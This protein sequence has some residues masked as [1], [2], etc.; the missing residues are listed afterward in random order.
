MKTP[1]D[2]LFPAKC[3]ICG[4]LLWDKSSEMCDDCLSIWTSARLARCP[5][6]SKTAKMCQCRPRFL[7]DTDKIGESFITSLSFYGSQISTD[8]RDVL[9]RRLVYSVKRK[10]SKAT[11]KFVARELSREILRILIEA[12][13]NKDDFYLTYPPRAKSSVIKYGFDQ[14]KELAKE[15]SKYTGI[16]YESILIHRGRKVQ[17]N[18]S[19]AERI[20]NANLSYLVK[21]KENVNGKKYI[22]IDDVITTGSTLNACAVKLK[23]SGASLVFPVCVAKLKYK[24]RRRWHGTLYWR[25]VSN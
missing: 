6:C 24:K 14:S 1:L 22:I 5:V 16:K 2:F 11:V 19:R 3:I 25:K 15:I 12:G 21:D 4:D 23:E 10:Q 9:T 20:K 18:L 13:E 17:K 7:S 8:L